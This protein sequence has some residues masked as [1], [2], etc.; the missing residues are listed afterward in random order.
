[1]RIIAILSEYIRVEP[2]VKDILLWV[3]MGEYFAF[4]EE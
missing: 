4:L 1:M 3:T 2:Q